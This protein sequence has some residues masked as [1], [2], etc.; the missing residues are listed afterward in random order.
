MKNRVPQDSAKALSHA[1]CSNTEFLGLLMV[2]NWTFR[3]NA[4]KKI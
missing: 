1:K 3:R 2:G 4:T